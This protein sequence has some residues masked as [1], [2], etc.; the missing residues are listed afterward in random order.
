MMEIEELLKNSQM[1]SPTFFQLNYFVIGKEPTPQSKMHKCIEEIRDRYKA[2]K[3]IKFEID[4]LKDQ[5]ELLSLS[6]IEVKTSKDYEIRIRQV[7]RKI[8]S[9]IEQ[10]E[11]L[12]S[13]ID[14]Y[15]KEIKFLKELFDQI[16]ERVPLKPWDDY[17]V[18]L[19]YWNAKMT[20]EINTRAIMG[21]PADLET[22]KLISALPDQM[23]IKK[24]LLSH[25]EKKT[26]PKDK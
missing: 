20:Q 3:N 9:N 15:E 25:I 14:S 2:I 24:Q 18:Q 19:E 26:L 10:I 5:N 23:P 8:D 21:L 4:E 11:F 6:L 7:D 1:G 16:N 22:I 17:N 13:K 12:K